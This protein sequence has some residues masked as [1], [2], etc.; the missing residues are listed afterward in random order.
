MGPDHRQYRSIKARAEQLDV[1][2]AAIRVWINKGKIGHAR[3]GRAIRIS[4]KA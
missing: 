4:D 2:I 1:S 3:F